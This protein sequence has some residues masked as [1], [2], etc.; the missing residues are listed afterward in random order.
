MLRLSDKELPG[1]PLPTPS[2]PLQPE[3]AAARLAADWRAT[4][5]PESIVLSYLDRY[6]EGLVGHP[7]AP[8]TTGRAVAVVD[9]TNNVIEQSF[10]V[11]KQGRLRLP[12]Q[13][14]C[15]IQT[16]CRW[17]AA[18]GTNCPGPSPNWIVR[19]RSDRPAW[20]APTGMRNRVAGTDRGPNTPRREWSPSTQQNHPQICPR[21]QL[22]N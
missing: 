3:A 15:S 21:L 7:V 11:A 19:H 18:P 13:R 17:C 14:T 6:G 9:R 8:D 16:T 22:A 4:F 2:A 20:N 12:W 1:D 5:Q 10:A